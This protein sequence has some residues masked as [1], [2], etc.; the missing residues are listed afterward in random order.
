M[1]YI[2][3]NHLNSSFEVKL[4][5]FRTKLTKEHGVLKIFIYW[6]K[7]FYSLNLDIFLRLSYNYYEPSKLNVEY[8]ST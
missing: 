7:V 3:F 6:F 4:I 5:D 1:K 8:I 2:G